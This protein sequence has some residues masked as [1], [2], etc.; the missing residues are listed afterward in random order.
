MTALPK[1]SCTWTVIAGLMASVETVFVGCWTK[2]SLLAA[3]ALTV[4]LAL[5]PVIELVTVSVAV[6]VRVPAVFSVTPLANVWL[7]LSPATNV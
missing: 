3:A 1:A 2:I 6:T 5:V 7:P 4:M